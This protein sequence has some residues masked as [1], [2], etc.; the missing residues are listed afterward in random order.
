M[1]TCVFD[2]ETSGLSADFG[3]L[4]C[5]V[6]KEIG[7]KAK[8]FRLDDYTD[9]NKKRFDDSKLA[10]AIKKELESYDIA[11]SWNGYRFDTPFLNS[12]L[13]WHNKELIVR[14]KPRHIDLMYQAKYKLRLHDSRLDTVARFLGCDNEKTRLDG[15]N[16]VRAMTGDRKSFN[17]IVKHCVLDCK[18]LEEVFNKLKGGIQNIC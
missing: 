14:G 4:L 3:I 13:K 16:W 5:G 12:R 18:V 7:K 9:W 1:R 2:L 10:Q 8:V 17:V 11:V 15:L 6:V